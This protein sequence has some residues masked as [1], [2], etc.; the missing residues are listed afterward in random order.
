MDLQSRLDADALEAQKLTR[1]HFVVGLNFSVESLR[2]LDPLCD[3]ASFVLPGGKNEAN[4]EL[5]T[6]VWGAYLG[7]V[8]R[9]ASDGAWTETA[10][11]VTLHV[12]GKTLDPFARVRLRLQEG[13]E[14]S[15]IAYATEA[16]G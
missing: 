10:E 12:A 13:A 14:H 11:G 6:R 9:R 4:M 15:L 1:K 2:E 3:D 8:L 7:E 16:L 5:L